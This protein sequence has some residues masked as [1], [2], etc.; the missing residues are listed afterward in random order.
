MIQLAK[1]NMVSSNLQGDIAG[2]VIASVLA[3]P[4][5][6]AYG[7]LV[8][9]PLGPELI[10]LGVVAG[11]TGLALSNIGAALFGSVS[12]MNN[13]PQSL[14][15]V[16]L[17]SALLSVILVHLPQG[18]GGERETG[19]A[20][21]LLFLL[22]FMVG[23][24]QL[25]LGL[26]RLGELAKYIPHP[27]L[28]G[29][30]NGTAI[31]IL[32]G[33]L[34]PML[35]IPDDAPLQSLNQLL[36]EGQLL[37]LIAG[38]TTCLAIWF[39]P[40]LTGKIPA[41]FL[42]IFAGTAIYYLFNTLGYGAV[43]G[44]VVGE[45][46]ANIPL[47][48]YAFEFAQLFTRSDLLP[49][50]FQLV[51]LAV[52]IALVVSLESLIASV[53]ADN[54]TQQRSNANQELV[55]Q[56]VGNI[57]SALFGGLTSGGAVGRTV[58]NY[59]YGG[60]T[61]ASR[62]VSGLFAIAVLLL[63]YSLAGQLPRVVLAGTLVVLAVAVFDESSLRLFGRLFS[64]EEPHKELVLADLVVI[65]LVM[66]V[67]IFVGS[68]RAITVGIVASILLFVLRMG[69]H[70][71][72]RHY[73]AATVRSNTQRPQRELQFLEQEGH[74]IK[75]FELEGSLFFGTADKI[76]ASVDGLLKSEVDYIILDLKQVTEVD[77]TGAY[78]LKQLHSRCQKYNK[79]LVL[80]SVEADIS[81]Q[82][83]LEFMDVLT[84]IGRYFDNVEDAIA[85]AEDQLLNRYL[86]THRYEIEIA[87]SEVDA[88][89]SLTPE[90]VARLLPYLGKSHYE[91]E[92]YVFHQGDEGDRIFFIVQ[93]RAYIYVDRPGRGR[94]KRVDTL[95]PGTTF[96]E[97]AIL[98]GK[99]RSANVV[100]EGKLI[101]YY[102]LNSQLE[103]LSQ[104]QP[105]IAYKL[106]IGL[107]KEFS[108][109]IRVANQM[110]MEL[111]Q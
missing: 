40:L 9:A 105:Q 22:A 101:C 108:T 69:K 56:G 48:R 85:W 14:S 74:R 99:P 5:S 110:A 37:T 50:I 13:G 23:V 89:M 72:R 10:P 67:L 17:R 42:G 29:L 41:P 59:N 81:G 96:G 57:L 54:L 49:V 3:L 2:G 66:L 47:P 20:L 27:V 36:S 76:A 68:L 107:G 109:R 24:F 102:L 12:I 45:I 35:G 21:A 46:P 33:Q 61:A 38:L 87:L 7:A 90:E 43:L 75:V 11:L 6:M 55:G 70:G 86:S 71:I 44:P 1:R 19:T 53:S 94:M 83:S 26:F 104:E 15:A 8:F 92:A 31:L 84:A 63:L 103:R 80:S 77:S 93:G 52:S 30:F 65:L 100:A 60:R 78:I 58:A 79:G 39:G 91:A 95:D 4:Q 82:S 97:M 106:L 32:I 62:M 25:L 98:E 16:M 51:P 34:K 73:S 18:S 88:L 28:S 111:R 64:R